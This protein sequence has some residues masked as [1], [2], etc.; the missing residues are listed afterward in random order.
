MK[1]LLL[2]IAA[3]LAEI[4]GGYLVWLWIKDAKPWWFGAA[5]SLLLILYGIIPTLQNY[6]SFG[7]VYAAYGGIFIVLALLWGWWIDKN[8]PDVYDWIGAALCMA[9]VSVILWAPRH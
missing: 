1:S 3:G 5:G 2:F 9:G 4:G 8:T 7:R 6:P